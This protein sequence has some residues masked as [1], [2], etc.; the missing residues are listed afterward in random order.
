MRTEEIKNNNITKG[1]KKKQTGIE[2]IGN[3]DGQGI[4]RRCEIKDGRKKYR[5][6]KYESERKT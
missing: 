2:G 4:L 5:K 6:E 3:G 1:Q